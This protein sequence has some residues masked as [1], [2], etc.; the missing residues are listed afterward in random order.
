MPLAVSWAVPLNVV[1]PEILN[2][3]KGMAGDRIITA[4]LTQKKL[5]RESAVSALTDEIGKKLVERFGASGLPW[6]KWPPTVFDLV[7][8]ITWDSSTA[9]LSIGYQQLLYGDTATTASR[10]APDGNTLFED[11]A[12]YSEHQR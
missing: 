1:P 11:I 7:I 4:L 10:K 12:R 9:S 6:S 5:E 2:E 3:A 8:S